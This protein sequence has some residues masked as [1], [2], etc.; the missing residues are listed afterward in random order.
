MICVFASCER[1]PLGIVTEKGNSFRSLASSPTKI[2]PTVDVLGS[3]QSV[4]LCVQRFFGKK[5]PR[6]E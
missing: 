1:N 4:S 2:R 6:K 3:G 5:Q